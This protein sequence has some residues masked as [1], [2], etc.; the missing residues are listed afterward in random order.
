M[1]PLIVIILGRPGCGKG[2]QAK[3]LQEKFGIDYIGSGQLLREKLKVDHNFS[4][5]KLKEVMERGDLVPSFL[6]FKIWVDKV[7]AIKNRP[8]FKGAVFDGN[9]RKILEARLMEDALAWYDWLE[10]AKVIVIDISA[11]ESYA[12]LAQRRTCE[13]CGRVIP[14]YGHFKKLE[15][16]DQC[17]GKLIK[18]PDDDPEIIRHR[19]EVFDL[20]VQPVID[21]FEKSGLLINVDGNRSIEEVHENIVKVLENQ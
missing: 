20:E 13:K 7:D 3:M 18:R 15:T 19:L 12:R 4:T 1:K 21:H 6:V 11:E 17:G 5:L 9:P 10:F 8:D 14:F 2:T 16:C